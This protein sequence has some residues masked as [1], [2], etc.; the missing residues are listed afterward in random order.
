M[1]G[2]LNKILVVVMAAIVFVTGVLIESRIDVTALSLSSAGV[3]VEGPVNIERN[4]GQL[5]MEKKLVLEQGDVITVGDSNAVINFADALIY[6]AP[7]SQVIFRAVNND[8]FKFELVKG[9]IWLNSLYSLTDI[10]IIAGAAL[11]K[12]ARSIVDIDYDASVAKITAQKGHSRVNLTSANGDVINNYLLVEGGKTEVG[13]DKVFSNSALIGKLYY[14][15]LIKEF[16]NSLIDK[17]KWNSDTW[18]SGNVKMDVELINSKEKDKL[19]SIN[20]RSLKYAS[21]ESLGF[22]IDR[23]LNGLGDSLTFIR[24]KQLDRLRAYIMNQLYDSEYLLIYGRN[25]EA[26]ERLDLF[27]QLVHSE[28]LAHGDQFKGELFALIRSEYEKLFFVLPGNELMGVKE[29]LADSLMKYSDAK[30]L[31]FKA[32]LIREYLNYAFTLVSTDDLKA[33]LALDTYFEKLKNFLGTVKASEVK[34]YLAE[35]SQIVDNLLRQYP[36]FYR[37]NVFI[38]KSYIEAEWLKI[39]VDPAEKKEEQQSIASTKIDFLKNLQVFFLDQKVTLEDTR[40]IVLRLINEIKDLQ[41]GDDVGINELFA[42]RLKDYGNFLRFLNSTTVASLRG[43]SPEKK[44]DEYM[45][46]HQEQVSIDQAISEFGL[47]SEPVQTV[48]SIKKQIETDFSDNGIRELKLAD[49][50]DVEQKVIGILDANYDGT[51]FTAMYDWSKKLVLE[52]SVSGEKITQGTIRLASVPL[53]IDQFLKSKT[54]VQD[55]ENKTEQDPSGNEGVV[56]PQETDE[57]PKQPSQEEMSKVEKVA[58]ILLMQKFKA[59]SLTVSSENINVVDI[60]E[61]IYELTAVKAVSSAGASLSFVYNNK[62]DRVSSLRV[63]S[64]KGYKEFNEIYKLADIDELVKEF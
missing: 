27:K 46:H 54:G 28:M 35:E 48:E 44:F 26:A 58:R 1:L 57:T 41:A 43:S 60:D 14:S 6:V 15:K 53:V 3:V 40:V 18:V 11:V 56:N 13:N 9:R 34:I 12:P 23:L 52:I 51:N 63:D 55:T 19:N 20:A 47:V 39:I 59:N 49:M 32:D 8:T 17:I 64:S 2:Y 21:L 31:E 33:R 61:Q 45:Q 5:A 37:E 16:Q 7:G 36:Q 50:K 4:E 10:E 29:V 38:M 62:T 42:L 22:Q 24:E 25:S 30:D